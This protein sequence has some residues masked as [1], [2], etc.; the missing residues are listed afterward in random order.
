MD[1]GRRCALDIWPQA[2]DLTTAQRLCGQAR[3]AA[4]CRAP[5]RA[6]Q[7]LHRLRAWQHQQL[8]GAAGA[9]LGDE[10]QAERVA[11]QQRWRRERTPPTALRA[12]D[13]AQLQLARPRDHRELPAERHAGAGERIE[14][15]RTGDSEAP[16][17]DFDRDL[18]WL[19]LNHPPLAEH[20]LHV[21]ATRADHDRGGG[22]QADQQ[23]PDAADQQRR[24]GERERCQH[25]RQA[26][27]RRRERRPQRDRQ[28]LT[29]LALP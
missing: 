1:P 20:P 25:Q 17:R 27:E 26:A 11:E 2:I 7:P 10:H 3:Q 28:A 16:A 22:Q 6:R 14:D 21:P 18:K 12:G 4:V 5:A 23:E 8:V 29:M 9:R 13:D 15:L 24:D 19:I